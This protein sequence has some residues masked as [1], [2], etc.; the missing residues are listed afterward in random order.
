M[1]S[2]GDIMAQKIGEVQSRLPY[3]INIGSSTYTSNVQDN[4]VEN[5]FINDSLNTEYSNEKN[6]DFDDILQDILETHRVN[7]TRYSSIYMPANTEANYD[8]H[9]PEVTES[10]CQSLYNSY[11]P[12]IA[13]MYNSY[14]SDSAKISNTNYDSIIECIS[15]RYSVPSNLI[16]S[17]IWQNPDLTP[18]QYHMQGLWDLCSSCHPPL[19][20]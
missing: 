17:V 3:G 10:I 14:V 2:V 4:R 5:N 15:N 18:M 1:Y 16:K 6:L 13:P 9:I 19:E 11:M 8:S 12:T 7:P 20:G